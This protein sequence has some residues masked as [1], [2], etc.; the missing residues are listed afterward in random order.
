[1]DYAHKVQVLS[2]TT[3]YQD[4][5]PLAITELG[6]VKLVDTIAI[7]DWVPYKRIV[8]EHTGRVVMG[9]GVFEVKRINDGDSEF[10]WQEITPVPYGVIGRAAF[11]AAKPLLQLL[12]DVSLKKLK[13][14]L[15]ARS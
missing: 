8:I 4:L 10:I 1:M 6:A 3:K 5:T 11:F 2:D 13:H 14:N 7:T 9:K 12:F 15:E